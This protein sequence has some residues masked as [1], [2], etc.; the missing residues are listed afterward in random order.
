MAKMNKAL[1]SDV[2]KLLKTIEGLPYW[3]ARLVLEAALDV[4]QRYSFL[5]LGGFVETQEVDENNG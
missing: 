1:F 5:D 3:E 2:K 4:I